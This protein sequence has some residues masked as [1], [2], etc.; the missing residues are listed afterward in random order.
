MDYWYINQVRITVCLFKL[1]S[2]RENKM[3]QPVYTKHA[4]SVF[5]SLLTGA[6]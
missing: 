6:N 3:N 1:Y 2:V 4:P 5:M